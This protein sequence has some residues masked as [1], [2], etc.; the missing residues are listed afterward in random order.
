ME[1]FKFIHLSDLHIFGGQSQRNSNHKH[2]IPHMKGIQKIVEKESHNL[3]RLIISGDI[4]H[5]GDEDNLLKAKQW[6]YSSMEIGNDEKISLGLKEEDQDKIKLV[7]GNHDAWNSKSKI[8]KTIDIRQKSLENF[9][10]SFRRNN[11]DVIPSKDGYYYDW[12]QKNDKGIFFIFLDSSFIGDTQIEKENPDLRVFDK[13]A[14][15]KFS[16][17]QAEKVLMLYDK[18]MTGKLKIPNNSKYIDKNVFAK[19]LK[20]VVM[21]HYLFEPAGQKREL[22]LQIKETESVFRNFALADIDL[23]MCGH[24]HYAEVKDHLYLHHFNK[25]AKARYIFNYFRR[26][27]GI[28]SLPFQYSD[29]KGKKHNKFLSALISVYLKSKYKSQNDNEEIKVDKNFNDTL[30]SILISGIDNPQNFE[31]EIKKFLKK[32]QTETFDDSIIDEYELAEISRRIKVSFTD[33]EREALKELTKKLKHVIEEL[34]SRQF[35]QLMAGS[36]C[37]KHDGEEKY[38]SFN[39]YRITNQDDGYQ[40]KCEKYI[41][42]SER[43]DFNNVPVSVF[44]EFKDKNRPLH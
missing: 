33:E 10:Y 25:R 26:L 8:G 38:R 23:L 3:D 40:I 19:S 35:V 7:P 18:G 22:L 12:I 4:S 36:A 42:N 28:Q 34:F 41:W 9:N 31:S 21:H 2:S 13:I 24:K 27:I 37:K 44:Y 5:Y 20:I 6:I 16:K 14:K 39:I 11:K 30:S 17:E 15:G 29:K 32:N 1:D 43:D